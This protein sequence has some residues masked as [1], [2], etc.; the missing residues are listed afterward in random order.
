MSIGWP[1][2]S[3]A[4]AWTPVE[5]LVERE[6]ADLQRCQSWVTGCAGIGAAVVAACPQP[7]TPM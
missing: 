3:G 7:S 2:T 1:S 4:R 5:P 6:L